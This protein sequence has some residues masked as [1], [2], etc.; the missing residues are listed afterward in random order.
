MTQL[1]FCAVILPKVP[2][3]ESCEPAYPWLAAKAELAECYYS[4][5]MS[6]EKLFTWFD[7]E[8]AE[9]AKTLSKK[10]GE[11]VVRHGAAAATTAVTGAGG[12]LGVLATAVS[13]SMWAVFQ[14][15]T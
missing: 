7:S 8:L 12:Y 15:A 5:R 10:V 9:G 2:D 11:Q 13:V 3:P 14:G 4:S 6:N 1:F